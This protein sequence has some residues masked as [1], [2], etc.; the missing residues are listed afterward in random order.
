MEWGNVIDKAPEREI[1]SVAVGERCEGGG[2]AGLG[3][4]GGCSSPKVV[5]AVRVGSG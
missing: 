3:D 4:L 2:L 5:K 1:P